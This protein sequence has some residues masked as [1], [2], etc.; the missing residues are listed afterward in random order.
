[1]II[2]P[3]KMFLFSFLFFGVLA[4]NNAYSHGLIEN[5]PSREY[6][7]GKV[8]KPEHTESAALAYEECRPVLTKD[9]K[10]NGDIY[11][12]MSVL[13]HSRGYFQNPSPPVNVCG[14]DTETFQGKASPWDAPI[15]WPINKILPGPKQFTWDISY[16]PHFS[17]TQQ[18]RYWIT[19]PDFKF[20]VGTPLKWSDFESAPFCDIPWDDN[21]P[22][23]TPAI[24]ADRAN[25]KFHMV[26]NFLTAQADMSSMRNGEEINPPLKDFTL[27]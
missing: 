12:F 22:D 27:V 9:G 24:W 15:N 6:F 5:P 11:Q 4:F 26:A 16:G 23:K 21:A 18:F 7:C 1:M 2:N 14:Y 19:K 20:A 10:Y 13:S 17:D 3:L 25:N 8:T